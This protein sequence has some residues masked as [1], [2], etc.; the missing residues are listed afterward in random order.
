MTTIDVET[1]ESGEQQRQRQQEKSQEKQEM[2]EVYYSVCDVVV[3]VHVDNENDEDDDNTTAIV[4][5]MILSDYSLRIVSM[6]AEIVF[7]NED[8]LFNHA[9]FI[10]CDHNHDNHNN[11]DANNANNAN[12]TH[13]ENDNTGGNN[14]HFESLN[15]LT[16]LSL[17]SKVV[18]QIVNDTNCHHREQKRKQRQRQL[19]SQ[20]LQ[21]RMHQDAFDRWTHSTFP[22]QSGAHMDVTSHYYD[23]QTM[24]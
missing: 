21:T 6:P 11:N 20:P 12:T 9:W 4:T 5:G 1:E 10:Q 23:Y 8:S 17:Q 18:Q 2:E 13:N 22:F 16:T 24:W 14:S 15:D 7:A 3:T 19:P